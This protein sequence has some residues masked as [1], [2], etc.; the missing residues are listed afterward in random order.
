MISNTFPQNS[1]MIENGYGLESINKNHK[2]LTLDQMGQIRG[3]LFRIMVEETTQLI[4]LCDLDWTIQYI[5]RSGLALSGYDENEVLGH[6]LSE[7][8]RQEKF[9]RIRGHLDRVTK[10]PSPV[11]KTCETAFLHGNGNEVAV[12]VNATPTIKQGV[13]NG[14]LIT[15]RDISERQRMQEEITRAKKL[16]SIGVLAGGIAHDYNNLLTAIMGYMTLAE[17]ILRPEDEALAFLGRARHA[18]NM[19]KNL[20]NKLITF[21][22]GGKPVKKRASVL[23]LLEN[24]LSFALTGSNIECEF[25]VTHDLRHVE[26]DDSQMSQAIHNIVMNAREAMPEGGTLRV[27]AQNMPGWQKDGDQ[28]NAGDWVR[29]SIKDEGCGISKEH[30]DR[31]FDPYFSTKEMGAQ[32]GLGL[33]L[34]ISHSIVRKHQ[35]YLFAE[36]EPGMG[37]SLHIYLPASN[38]TRNFMA[39]RPRSVSKEGPLRILVMDDEEVVREITGKML[40][41]AGYEVGLARTGSEAVR[42]FTQC[43]EEG[44]PFHVLLLDLTVRGGMGGKEVARRLLEMEPN[45]KALVSSGFS[46]DPVM[47]DCSA[48]GFS[49]AITKP[50]SMN[51]L[52]DKIENTVS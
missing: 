50:Y 27:E 1:N 13:K 28:E 37:T 39:A 44:N 4:L 45:L 40:S 7:F 41:H 51:E 42:M 14:F 29:I 31:I 30:L 46:D 22:K 43:M 35:G 17:S 36:S 21:A 26:Y 33:G 6:N 8:M 52:L 20:T 25:L 11:E 32:K 34:S 24:T 15:A 48:Y 16:E 47:T 5:N 2:V 3:D 38:P 12:E 9:A 19:A 10:T 23:P 18:A 49:D